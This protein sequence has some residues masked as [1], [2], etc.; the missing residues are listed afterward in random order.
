MRMNDISAAGQ[1]QPRMAL[2]TKVINVDMRSAA[3]D[4]KAFQLCDLG[5]A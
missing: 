1:A 2:A 4:M 3:F 5:M